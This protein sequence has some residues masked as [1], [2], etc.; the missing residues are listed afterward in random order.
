MFEIKV[1]IEHATR[2]KSP[3]DNGVGYAPVRSIEINAH[4]PNDPRGVQSEAVVFGLL[5]AFLTASEQFIEHHQC[6]GDKIAVDG[7]CPTKRHIHSLSMHIRKM[8]NE[9]YKNLGLIK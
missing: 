6:H 8:N 7:M 5:G 4:D 2:A 9:V 1:T 3:N